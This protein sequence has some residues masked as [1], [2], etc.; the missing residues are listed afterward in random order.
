LAFDEFE[1]INMQG[2]LVYYG[3]DINQQDFSNLPNGIYFL[4][5]KTQ[6]NKS[7][8]LIKE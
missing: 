3:H 6:P 5:N 1:L 7:S 4:N 8:K 2:K